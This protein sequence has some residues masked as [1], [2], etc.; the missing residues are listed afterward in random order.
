MKTKNTNYSEGY[1][2]F[3]LSA[4]TNRLLIESCQ[5]SGRTKNRE[6]VLRLED[7]LT[8]FSA[9]QLSH[10]N[11]GEELRTITCPYALIGYILAHTD[12]TIHSLGKLLEIPSIRLKGVDPLTAS[13][14]MRI[15]EL[16]RL[17]EG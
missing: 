16:K 1:I 10:S 12:Y 9:I 11:Q 7:H 15:G 17:L 8:Q 13:D 4:E 2:T 6:A 5:R 14:C 3:R